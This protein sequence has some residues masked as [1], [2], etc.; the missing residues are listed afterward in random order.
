MIIKLAFKAG[1]TF[2][3]LMGKTPITSVYAH[4]TKDKKKDMHHG[5]AMG[6]GAGIGAGILGGSGAYALHKANKLKA[7]PFYKQFTK[8][9]RDLA[10]IIKK[11]KNI[12]KSHKLAALG[13]LTASGAAYG[14]LAGLM[15]N[16]NI[17]TLRAAQR[18]QRDVVK[19][20][21]I[22]NPSKLDV[23]ALASS[24]GKIKNGAL[25]K[26]GKSAISLTQNA[27]VPAQAATTTAVKS[28]APIARITPAMGFASSGGGQA[29]F[30][31]KK[32]GL[33]G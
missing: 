25:S 27:A 14:S 32:R 13:V 26:A 30:I 9:D 10:T 31:A 20:A 29:A 2:D 23:S 6:I 18:G 4:F 16:A 5:K 33:L 15:Q 17:R 24:L 3:Q 1:G 12:P 22:N 7:K 11:F 19:T 8:H 28:F 21:A